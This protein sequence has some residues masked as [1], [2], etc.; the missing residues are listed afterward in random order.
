M[1]T[2]LLL[3]AF[4]LCQVPADKDCKDFYEKNLPDEIYGKVI[5]KK[6][7]A[8]HYRITIDDSVQKKHIEILL[9]KNKTGKEIFDFLEKESIVKKRKGNLSLSALTPMKG[10]G[11]LNGQSFPD[12][13]K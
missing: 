11:G 13:C 6:E 9:V 4:L 5:E 2:L 7:D 8:N 12:L 10:G 1:K 3:F